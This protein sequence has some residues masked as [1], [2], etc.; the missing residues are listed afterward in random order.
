MMQTFT[1]AGGFGW[2]DHDRCDQRRI[3]RDGT[4][5]W[6]LSAPPSHPSPA[7]ESVTLCLGPESPAARPASEMAPSQQI[8]GIFDYDYIQAKNPLLTILTTGWAE[9]TTMVFFPTMYVF[10]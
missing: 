2:T 9:N 10:I 8:V 5:G 7:P 3:L 4:F 1:T 6:A